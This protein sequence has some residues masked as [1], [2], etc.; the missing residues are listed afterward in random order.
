MDDVHFAF[1]GVIMDELMCA[2]AGGAAPEPD[3]VP[4]V[5]AQAAAA[6]MRREDSRVQVR[7]RIF[8]E[9]NNRPERKAYKAQYESKKGGSGA[10]KR[11]ADSHDSSES[12]VGEPGV[13]SACM[14]ALRGPWHSSRQHPVPDVEFHPLQVDSSM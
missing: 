2:L 3:V 14:R 5:L 9:K 13:P 11:D 6:P 12:E 4:A 10:P 8:R 7:R 1:A